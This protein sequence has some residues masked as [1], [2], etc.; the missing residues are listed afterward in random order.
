MVLRG[1]LTNRSDCS[2]IDAMKR[3]HTISLRLQQD[4]RLWLIEI[5]AVDLGARLCAQA[6]P[7]PFHYTIEF[8]KNEINNLYIF[9]V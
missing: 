3:R 8:F 2:L 5:H 9:C 7:T 1:A 4:L 6:H